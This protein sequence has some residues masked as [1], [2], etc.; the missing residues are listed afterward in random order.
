MTNTDLELAELL[1][2]KRKYKFDCADV[3]EQ[4]QAAL[5][6]ELAAQKKQ[7]TAEYAAMI[8]KAISERLKPIILE[9]LQDE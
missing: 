1:E 4:T 7:L 8:T 3:E 5:K 2:L 9:V 6:R